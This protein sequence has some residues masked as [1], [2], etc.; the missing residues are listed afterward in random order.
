MAL[1][2]IYLYYEEYILQ[3]FLDRILTTLTQE[4]Y[5]INQTNRI[6]VIP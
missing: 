1:H 4:G 3:I 6:E 5:Y 2:L